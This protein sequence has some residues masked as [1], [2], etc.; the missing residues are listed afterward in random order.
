MHHSALNV[1][2][3][4]ILGASKPHH[5]ENSMANLRKGPLEDAVVK[6]L[7]ALRTDEV[8]AVDHELVDP[9]YF[10]FG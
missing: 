2:D 7:N 10:K 3:I 4:V 8:K 9:K 1:D 5:I 6:E